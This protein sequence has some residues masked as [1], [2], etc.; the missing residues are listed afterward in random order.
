LVLC[1]FPYVSIV[2][3]IIGLVLGVVGRKKNTEV[4]APSGM[5][6]AGLV[7]SIVA[8]A[9]SVVVFATCTAALCAT[10]NAVNSW[11]PNW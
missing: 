7:L 10:R 9:V 6:I 2:L 5:A 4:G 11:L 8:L 1:W 3:A